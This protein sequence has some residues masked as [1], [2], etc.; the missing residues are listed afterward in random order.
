M[1]PQ[2]PCER[3]LINRRLVEIVREI[4]LR[5]AYVRAEISR[6]LRGAGAPVRRV[7]QTYG[8]VTRIRVIDVKHQSAG[9]AFGEAGLQALIRAGIDRDAEPCVLRIGSQSGNPVR[10]GS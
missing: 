6:V 9:E 5:R 4:E 10:Q 1:R 3:K 8:S 2:Q 7:A